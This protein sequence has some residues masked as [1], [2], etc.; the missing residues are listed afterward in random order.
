M[1]GPDRGVSLAG[2][3]Q[4]GAPVTLTA[5]PVPARRALITRGGTGESGGGAAGN[6]ADDSAIPVARL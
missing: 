4:R 5:S 3:V 1:A 6:K 2:L